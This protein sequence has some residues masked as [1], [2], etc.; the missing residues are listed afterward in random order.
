MSRRRAGPTLTVIW[1]RDIPAQ[2]VARDA[3]RSAKAALPDRFQAAID[4]A[5]MRAGTAGSGE[6]LDLW[7]RR[8]R[9]CGTDLHAEVDAEIAALDARFPPATL[10][11]LANATQHDRSA[12]P[13]KDART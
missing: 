4:R 1:W 5:A 7:D 3:S 6:Y 13:D 8:T 12:D 10:A 9:P 11:A 2:V